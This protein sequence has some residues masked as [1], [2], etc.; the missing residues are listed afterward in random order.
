MKCFDPNLPVER[1]RGRKL[2]HWFQAGCTVYVTGRLADSLPRSAY[3]AWRAAQARWLHGLRIDTRDPAWRDAFKE[4]PGE[5]RR[6]FH[7]EFSEG[8]QRLLDRGHGAC[9]LREEPVAAVVEEAMQHFDG[10]RYLRGDGVLAGNHFHALLTPLPGFDVRAE[11]TK[12]KR[13]TAKRIHGI[14]GTSGRVWQPEAYDHLVRTPGRLRMI[15][16]YIASH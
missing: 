11:V 2:P 4:L 15:Q 9:I 5:V 14:R 13:I 16:E 7:A 8:F 1:T 6:R 10:V 12:W 3:K